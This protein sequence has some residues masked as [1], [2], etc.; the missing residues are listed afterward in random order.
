MNQNI[1]TTIRK[2]RQRRRIGQGDLAETLGVSVA[3]GE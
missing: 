3:G 1:G 2:L